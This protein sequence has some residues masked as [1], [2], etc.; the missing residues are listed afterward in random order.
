MP[1]VKIVDFRTLS[2]NSRVSYNIYL[3]SDRRICLYSERISLILLIYLRFLN[4]C[5]SIYIKIDW[6]NVYIYNSVFW[7]SI[8]VTWSMTGAAATAAARRPIT[9]GTESTIIHHCCWSHALSDLYRNKKKMG[10][11]SLS[12]SLYIYIY[13][14]ID[15]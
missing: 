5:I 7:W 1:R 10:R 9:F 13:I 8:H 3:L 11:I 6:V 4:V 14:Y 15:I 12:L 2:R